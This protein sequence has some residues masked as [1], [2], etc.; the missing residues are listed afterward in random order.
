MGM[1]SKHEKD[2]IL[3]RKKE[4]AMVKEKVQMGRPRISVDFATVLRMRDMENLGWSRMLSA[5][6]P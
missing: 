4:A 6:V 2:Q 1:E 3:R 5:F